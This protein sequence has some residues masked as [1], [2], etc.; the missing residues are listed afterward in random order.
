M[1]KSY[2]CLAESC[3]RP[4]CPD[5]YIEEH[6]GHPKKPLKAVYEKKRRE[7]DS[8]METFDQKFAQLTTYVSEM[9]E[10]AEIANYY[11]SEQQLKT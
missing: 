10:K 11:A 9:H 8:A 6:L 7:I 2:Y 4:L 3:Q 1:N 5:C